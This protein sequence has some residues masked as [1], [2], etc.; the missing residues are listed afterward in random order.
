MDTS[1]WLLFLALA[2]IIG[3]GIGYVLGQIDANDERKNK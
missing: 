3:C 2:A 1:I